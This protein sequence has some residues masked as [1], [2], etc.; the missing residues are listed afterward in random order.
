[1]PELEDI[2]RLAA[3]AREEGEEICLA[4][5]VGVEGSSYRKPGARML[6]TRSGRRAGTLSGGCL[7]GEISKKAWWLTEKGPSLQ[8]YSSYFDEDSG[9]PYGLGCGGTVI[10]LLERGPAAEAVV[11]ALRFS[12][13]NRL[14]AAILTE[15]SENSPG[16]RLIMHS[17]GRVTFAAT[18]A[19]HLDTTT[20]ESI[21]RPLLSGASHSHVIQPQG[22]AAIPVFCEHVAPPPALWIFGAG[23]DAQPLVKFAYSLGW[24]I[25]VADGRTHL[26]RTERFPYAHRVLPLAP[27]GSVNLAEEIGPDDAVVVM[28]HSYEQDHALLGQ[29]LPQPLAYL[30]VLGPRQRTLHILEQLTRPQTGSLRMTLDEAAA[31]LHS[32]VGLNISAHNPSAIA[33]SIAAEVQAA[34]AAHAAGRGLPATRAAASISTHGS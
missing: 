15:V 22:Q 1:M 27:A 7:E 14:P 31:R 24:D 29:L 3:R 30:G 16:T 5:V 26:A 9:A 28:T 20:M 2:L 18:G 32:P 34:L 10:V 6:L 33:L 17:P 11:D 25:T 4:T 21:T 23:D 13:D 8:R 12:V 19:P